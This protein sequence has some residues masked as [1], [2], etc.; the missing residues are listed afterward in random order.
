MSCSALV[1][2]CCAV[3]KPDFGGVEAT[4]P[5]M[6]VGFGGVGSLSITK[7]SKRRGKKKHDGNS[8]QSAP[9]RVADQ[10]G[11]PSLLRSNYADSRSVG[12]VHMRHD[13][14]AASVLSGRSGYDFTPSRF[15]SQYGSMGGG[16]GMAVPRGQ[17]VGDTF[18]PAGAPMPRAGSM[19]SGGGGSGRWPP[20][21]GPPSFHPSPQATQAAA[22]PPPSSVRSGQ[23]PQPPIQAAKIVKAVQLLHEAGAN[24]QDPHI[25]QALHLVSSSTGN[26]LDAVKLAQLLQMGG[27]NL[28]DPSVAS[29]FSMVVP[30]PTAPAPPPAMQA[31]IS[32]PGPSRTAPS[33]QSHGDAGGWGSGSVASAHPMESMFSSL[34]LGASGSRPSAA[35]DHAAST[36]SGLNIKAPGLMSTPFSTVPT[37]TA[38]T[39]ASST[40]GLS[41]IG[42]GS[43]LAGTPLGHDFTDGTAD[44][45]SSPMSAKHPGAASSSSFLNDDNEAPPWAPTS[46]ILWSFSLVL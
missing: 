44:G 1:T 34:H 41:S 20:P 25:E 19:G 16:G 32:R 2:L 8:V 12:P 18:Y 14:D 7:S 3:V 23:G 36:S 33:P 29:L 42:L 37:S 17:L 30:G 21:Q 11:F 31:P 10:G 24:L 39:F 4:T 46:N 13:D 6:A 15:A 28:S 38:S 45:S 26:P 9:T 40:Q 5:S 27:A 35:G 22:Q 43:L